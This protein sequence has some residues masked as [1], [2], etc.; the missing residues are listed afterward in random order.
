MSNT[1]YFQERAASFEQARR[2]LES[3]GERGRATGSIPRLETGSQPI[4]R[5]QAQAQLVPPRTITWGSA[6]KISV[7]VYFAVM[8]V[9]VTLAALVLFGLNLLAA[10]S[11]FDGINIQ[12]RSLTATAAP[13]T[14]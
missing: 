6:F 7:A 3:P 12:W 14:T 11:S 5:A 8:G 10:N 2:R 1:D 4:T 9:L 13:E